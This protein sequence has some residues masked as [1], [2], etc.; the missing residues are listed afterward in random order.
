[1]HHDAEEPADG[2]PGRARQHHRRTDRARSGG[3]CMNRGASVDRGVV[4]IRGGKE[5]IST[6]VSSYEDHRSSIAYARCSCVVRMYR[7]PGSA[8][9]NRARKPRT[10]HHDG[11]HGVYGDPNADPDPDP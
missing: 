7:V 11:D 8:V 4:A 6:H 9:D 5:A 3:S 10:A 1:M 2:L